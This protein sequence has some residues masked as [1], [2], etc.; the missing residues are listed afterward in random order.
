MGIWFVGLVIHISGLTNMKFYPLVMVG[1]AI[2]CT[3]NMC[4]VP[5]IK[6]IGL[7]MGL[8]IWCVLNLLAG[9][10]TGRYSVMF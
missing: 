1:G 7:A 8:L 3:G 2:W 4:V 5:I 6:T 9:W 10:A